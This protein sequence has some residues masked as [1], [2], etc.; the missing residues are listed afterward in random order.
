VVGLA[1]ALSLAGPSLPAQK[2]G[3]P[4][5]VVWRL[6]GLR[7]GM[8]VHLLVDSATVAEDLPP[9]FQLLR[10]DQAE[11]IHPSLRTVIES[12]PNFASWSPSSFCLYYLDAIDAGPVRV[13]SSNPQ[14]APML[15]MWTVGAIEVASGSR[16][17]V[18][19]QL[20]T[21]SGRLQRAGGAAGVRIREIRSSVGKVPENQDEPE[22]VTPDRAEPD[23]RYQLKIGKTVL[24][25]D[26]HPAADSTRMEEA[27][28]RHWVTSG[29]EVAGKVTLSAQW[30]RALIGSLRIEGKDAFA[31]ALKGSPTR[32]VGPLYQGGAGELALSR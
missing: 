12:Q 11:D 8:C 28:S 21:N 14:K 17:D 23:D 20:V 4:D 19:L 16:R 25:W 1:T 26:G 30:R 22:P 3:A 31:R 29:R 6:E 24:T 13:E 15:G 27:I 5:T 7:S 32:F 2:N 9:E 18:A 10:A